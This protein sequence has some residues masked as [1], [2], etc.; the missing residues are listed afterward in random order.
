M[1]IRPHY[2]SAVATAPENASVCQLADLMVH[3]AIGSVVIVD[4]ERRPVGIVTDRDL[5][6][7][8]IARG[9][10]PEKTTASEVASKPA[11]VARVDEPLEA[12]A[13]RMRD[14]GMRR[15]P[16]VD[17]GEKLVGLVTL[18]DLVVALGR[19]LESIGG[20]AKAEIEMARREGRKARRRVDI[21]EKLA[22][23]EASALAAGRDA[24]DFVTR[25]FES[26]RD[27]LASL[28]SGKEGRRD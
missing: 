5:C 13:A 8:V 21:E 6:T 20:T 18:D 7:R 3:Y 15:V 2:A 17:E 11:Q 14:A 4:A 16:I 19:E 25:E 24:V 12:V 9:L 22:S 27:R 28:R 23:L 1:M 26:L 10:D